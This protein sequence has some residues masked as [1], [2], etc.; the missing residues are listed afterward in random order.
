MK[1][2]LIIIFIL[3][4]LGL[5]GQSI[6]L[7]DDLNGFK[8]FKLG[9]KLAEYKDDLTYKETVDKIASY[10]HKSPEKF[11]FQ[12]LVPNSILLDFYGGELYDVM[13]FADDY[14]ASS[15][16]RVINELTLLFGR[17]TESKETMTGNIWIAWE[18]KKTKLYTQ[19]FVKRNTIC[20]EFK[21]IP[22]ERKIMVSEF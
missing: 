2:L 7:L 19:Y 9:N 13:L 11:E 22:I 5:S 15:Y 6:D 4:S 21:S 12:K 10:E 20:I 3:S 8:K 17:P 16:E 1:N 18:G 14:Q